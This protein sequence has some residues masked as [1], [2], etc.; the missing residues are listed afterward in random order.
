MNSN[1]KTFLSFHIGKTSKRNL[2]PYRVEVV[3]SHILHAMFIL[4]LI[5]NVGMCRSDRSSE[6]K[7]GKIGYPSG[8]W[9]QER[10]ES[11]WKVFCC[12]KVNKPEFRRENIWILDREITSFMML[13]VL[14]L[15]TSSPPVELLFCKEP[16]LPPPETKL[17]IIQ[18]TLDCT[19]LRAALF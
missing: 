4:E 13:S 14:L 18:L 8:R 19:L 17:D 3:Q 15:P 7:N 11:I 6:K 1:D 10:L 5:L 12:G 9:S 16:W 2:K